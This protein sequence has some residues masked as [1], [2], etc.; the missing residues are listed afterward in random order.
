[1]IEK[2]LAR[3]AGL[4]TVTA[5][6]TIVCDVD[7]AVM[8]D[9]QFATDW[10]QPLR[11]ADPDKVAVVMDHA[12]PTPTIKSLSDHSGG[13]ERVPTEFEE[14]PVDPAMALYRNR[15]LVPLRR[16]PVPHMRYVGAVA[17]STATCR[18]GLTPVR[19]VGGKMAGHVRA[20]PV[21]SLNHLTRAGDI[22][23]G[24][25]RSPTDRSSKPGARP[26]VCPAGYPMSGVKA[27]E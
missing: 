18:M 9:L 7:M 3:A 4:G 11:I 27:C 14:G 2:I 17:F 22:H 16:I 15:P 1:M 25:A 26:N 10:I 21:G 24:Q 13:A 8:I 23:T 19:R 12:V 5:G 20:T 6:Q